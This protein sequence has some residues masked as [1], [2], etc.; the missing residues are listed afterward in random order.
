[1]SGVIISLSLKLQIRKY[2][3]VCLSL[4]IRINIFLCFRTEFLTLPAQ[5]VQARLAN[6]HPPTGVNGV[7]INLPYDFRFTSYNIDPVCF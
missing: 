6:T 1:M 3:V 4:K 2:Q 5:A 7:I